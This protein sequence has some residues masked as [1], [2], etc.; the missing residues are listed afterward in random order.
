MLFSL[1]TGVLYTSLAFYAMK[2]FELVVVRRVL[3]HTVVC[4]PPNAQNKTY[5]QQRGRDTTDKRVTY[6][7]KGIQV[8]TL[9]R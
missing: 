6:G 4:G 2:N 9:L 3:A 1:G 5:K 7:M 8:L